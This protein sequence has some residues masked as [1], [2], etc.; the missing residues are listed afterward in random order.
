MSILFNTSI[1]LRIL[2]IS[3]TITWGSNLQN[4]PFH[5]ALHKHLIL[6]MKMSKQCQIKLEKPQKPMG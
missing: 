3:A 4:I 2:N 6:R 1:F 5:I